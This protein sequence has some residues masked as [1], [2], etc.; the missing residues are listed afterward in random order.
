MRFPVY[1]E[2]LRKPARF[3]LKIR[4]I[5]LAML[6]LGT[7]LFLVG[8]DLRSNALIGTG[9]LVGVFGGLFFCTIAANNAMVQV[10]IQDDGIHILD[11][12]GRPYQSA[13]YDSVRKIEIREIRI[14]ETS[15]DNSRHGPDAGFDARLIMI[16]INGAGCFEDLRLTRYTKGGRDVYWCD[17]VLHHS[18]CIALVYDE[19]A[20]ELLN[21]Q[22]AV[23]RT[24]AH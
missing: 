20:W 10:D 22:L 7:I 9:A 21:R 6:V 1:P 11:G 17:K 12:R 2:R 16:Y 8:S 18:N 3:L 5:L 23:H 19:T 14:T 13:P 24:K 4:Y 15:S